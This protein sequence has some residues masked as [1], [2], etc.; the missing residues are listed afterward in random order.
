MTATSFE[1]SLDTIRDVADNNGAVWF[2]HGVSE[3]KASYLKKSGQTVGPLS[4]SSGTYRLY[5]P[6]KEGGVT[7]KAIQ[8]IDEIAI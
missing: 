1:K 6:A 8:V 2:P 5:D 7:V 4:M 3:V